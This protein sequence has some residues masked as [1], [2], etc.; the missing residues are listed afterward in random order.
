MHSSSRTVTSRCASAVCAGVGI[1]ILAG[2]GDGPGDR[3]ATSAAG[4]ARPAAPMVVVPQ[5]V[6]QHQD[7]A[8]RIA[9]RRGLRLRWT[10]FAGKLANGR[11]NVSCVKIHSQSPVAG[12]RRP[13]GS[14]VAVIEIACRTPPGPPH[15]V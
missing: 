8:H 12:E 4:S 5:L 14:S 11:Y 2:C 3:A 1:V 9:T 7:A 10:A 13:R 15:G 6:G